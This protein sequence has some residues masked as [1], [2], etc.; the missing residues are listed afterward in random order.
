MKNP[1]K[2][3]A[4][5]FSGLLWLLL[6]QHESANGERRNVILALKYSYAVTRADELNWLLA[7]TVVGQ[8]WAVFP[9]TKS[10]RHKIFTQEGRREIAVFGKTPVSGERLSRRLPREVL[11]PT[12]KPQMVL[13]G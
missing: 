4:Y 1:K 6:C 7:G 9:W 3:V 11:L 2:T 13:T 8:R 12:E 10:Q 5:G